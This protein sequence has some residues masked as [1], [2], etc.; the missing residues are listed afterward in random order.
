MKGECRNLIQNGLG[1]FALYIFQSN[2]TYLLSDAILKPLGHTKVPKVQYKNYE[3]F[4]NKWGVELINWPFPPV[5]GPEA[6]TGTQQTR[7]LL[8]DLQTG[9][10]RWE[11]IAEGSHPTSVPKKTRKS[12]TS[13]K[14]PA[15]VDDEDTEVSPPLFYYLSTAHTYF[16]QMDPSPDAPASSSTRPTS[17]VRDC[18]PGTSAGTAA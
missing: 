3:N 17:P 6:I 1:A 5:K 8:E 10:C 2:T 13:T 18:S 7:V 4:V 16:T 11:I 14:S 9:K 12:T 15:T